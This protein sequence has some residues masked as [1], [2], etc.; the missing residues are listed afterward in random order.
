MGYPGKNA[1]F[2]S[3]MGKTIKLSLFAQNVIMPIRG[4]SERSNRKSEVSGKNQGL[5]KSG[6]ESEVES[7]NFQRYF[8]KA[9]PP[10]IG[11]ATVIRI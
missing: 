10:V 2:Q 11:G 9:C 1:F 8:I 4:H 6:S 3:N 7:S 5:E